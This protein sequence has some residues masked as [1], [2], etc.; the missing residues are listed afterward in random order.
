MQ[1]Y[2]DALV[3]YGWR[4]GPSC[5][6]HVQPGDEEALHAMADRIGLRRGW[7]QAHG[8][9]PHYD[10]T[11]YHRRLAIQS[12]A[13]PIDRATTVKNIRLWREARLKAGV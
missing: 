4:L 10:L 8:T 9:M 11:E 7:F 6:L 5:H 2:V 3:D 12:G 1:V 13:I